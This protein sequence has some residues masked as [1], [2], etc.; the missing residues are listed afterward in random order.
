MFSFL[1]C[2]LVLVCIPVTLL[3]AGIVLQQPGGSCSSHP[4]LRPCLTDLQNRCHILLKLCM[5]ESCAN[6]EILR[7]KSRLHPCRGPLELG[8]IFRS[9]APSH[10]LLSCTSSKI[11]SISAALHPYLPTTFES[12]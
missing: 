3:T 8:R 4:L 9:S 12:I 7:V 10:A 6:A 1:K 11:P 2:F 5:C